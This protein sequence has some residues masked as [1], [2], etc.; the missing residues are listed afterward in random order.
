MVNA[1]SLDNSSGGTLSSR[2]GALTLT[3]SGAL[4]NH[5]EGA[6]VSKGKLTLGAGSLNNA[7]GIVSTQATSA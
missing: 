6:L 1:A 4:D 7:G 3:L 5:N 2:D